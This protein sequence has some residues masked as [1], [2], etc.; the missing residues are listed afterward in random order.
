MDVEEFRRSPCGTLVPTIDGAW[1][2]VPDPLPPK[3][4]LEPVAALL[5]EASMYLGELKGIGR[6]AAKP[7]LLIRPLQRREAVASS[8]I[9]GAMTSLPEL[10]LFEA[11]ADAKRCP[12]G[13]REVGDYVRALEHATERLTRIPLSLWIIRQI[14]RILRDSARR[15]GRG[16]FPPGEFRQHQTWIGGDSAPSARFVPPPPD[17]LME[18]LAGL[19]KF[20][21]S[22][23][24][25]RIPPLIALAMVHYQFE[26][27]RP[28]ADGNGRLGRLLLP[29]MLL[30]QGV[31]PQPLLCFSPFFE[32][33]HGDYAN[34]L[35]NVSRRGAW[36][37]W[38]S[39]F[40]SAAREQC[41]DA[42]A[43][44]QALEEL[45]ARYA[46]LVRPARG[47]ALL[48]RLV[49]LAFAEPVFTIPRAQ[50][51]LGVTHRG[52]ALNVS[53]LVDRGL[54]RD[55]GQGRR[56]R[57]FLAHGVLEVVGSETPRPGP[58]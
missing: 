20:I 1:A 28:F 45:R 16:S 3:V 11:G 46:E 49:D 5:A 38:F 25:D 34:R 36:L 27:I 9:A 43:R 15:P 32:R 40:L 53:K 47:S 21:Q 22:T 17:R 58:A 23:T 12:P 8:A 50:E 30:S 29:L 39:F 42:I 52:A 7:E 37:D 48:L 31:L 14:H 56:P 41:R 44:I 2:F 57:Y 54:L 6:L 19:E 4:D 35:Y 51:V 55:M 18:S 10:Y 26:T 24:D 13:T 33:H